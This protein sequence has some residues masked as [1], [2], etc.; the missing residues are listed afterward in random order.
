L[1]AGLAQSSFGSIIT[2]GTFSINGT[3]Y[4]ANNGIDPDGGG[5]LPT[6]AAAAGCIFW[7]SGGTS[8]LNR[9]DISIS[10]LPS[11][12]I[13]LAISGNDAAVISNL[14]NPPDVVGVF[15]PQLFMSFLNGGVTTL[16]N[17]NQI[18]PGIY[19]PTCGGAPAPGQQCTPPGSLF[20]FVNNVA[21]R[22]GDQRLREQHILGH[23]HVDDSAGTGIASLNGRWLDRPCRTS[24]PSCG[25]VVGISRIGQELVHQ[26]V[27][28][29]TIPALRIC[30]RSPAWTG[31]RDSANRGIV[32]NGRT[33]LGEYLSPVRPVTPGA[34]P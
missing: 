29:S 24:A 28:N 32:S 16:L 13:P 5:P 30:C 1:L 33:P 6:C 27:P 15:P 9:A 31:R 19:P 14:F 23:N 11:G 10:G 21:C 34:Q 4:V 2:T 8:T 17:I 18:F 20:N 3:I 26:S 12:D 25:K 7:Q 22:L